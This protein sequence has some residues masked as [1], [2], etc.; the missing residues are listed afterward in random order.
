MEISIE[1]QLISEKSEPYF[2]AELSGNHDGDIDKAIKLIEVCKDIGVNA[3]KLQ[4]YTPDTMTLKCSKPDFQIKGGIWK[5]YNLYDLYEKAHTP[6][7]WHKILFKKAKDLDLTIF[8][9]P[10]DKTAIDLLESLNVSVYKIAS[11]EITDL[12]LIKTVAQT[13]KPIIL[14]TGMANENEVS[15]AIDIIKKF[16]NNFKLIL[17]HCVSGYPTPI[18]E[19]NISNIKYFKK[20]FKVIVGLSDHT[21]SDIAAISAITL[22]ARVIEKHLVLDRSEGGVDSEF[23]LE[24]QEFK[25]MIDNCRDAYESLGSPGFDL[26]KSEKANIIYRRSIYAS[27]DIKKGEILSTTNIKVVRPGYGIEPKHYDNIVGV[28]KAKTEIPFGKPIIWNDIE[29]Y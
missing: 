26:Q 17:M 18:S 7:D 28:T 23:S 14:S 3:V 19:I 11:F 24:P 29:D 12:N 22:G 15:E 1:K 2:I 21:K 6:W 27:K 8:S 5:G 20:K 4:T 13:N 10:F 9:T 25:K 16:S